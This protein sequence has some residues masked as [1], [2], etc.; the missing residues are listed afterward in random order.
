MSQIGL[1]HSSPFRLVVPTTLV[2]WVPRPRLCVG[3]S[4]NSESKRR[5]QQRTQRIRTYVKPEYYGRESV[6]PCIP[7]YLRSFEF[8]DTFTIRGGRA[9][10]KTRP[11]KAVDVAP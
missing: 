9:A 1:F 10:W 4:G 8:L 11:R 3:V 2:R 5:P 7:R 6:N